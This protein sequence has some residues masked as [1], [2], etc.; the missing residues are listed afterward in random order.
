MLFFDQGQLDESHWCPTSTAQPLPSLTDRISKEDPSLVT[1]KDESR[2][3][4]PG[5]EL[6]LLRSETGHGAGAQAGSSPRIEWWG[7]L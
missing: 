2:V 4:V 1:E 3:Q 5:T 6:R 7:G